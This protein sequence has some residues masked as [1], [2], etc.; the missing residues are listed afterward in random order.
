MSHELPASTTEP[1]AQELSIELPAVQQAALQELGKGATIT[2]AAQAA[3]V[4]RKTVSRWI[5]HDAVF[6][7]AYNAW[8]QELLDSGLGRA[9]AMSDAALTTIANAIQNGHVNASLQVVKQLGVLRAARPGSTDAHQP[10]LVRDQ[11][12]GHDAVRG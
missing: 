2:D 12:L 9:L 10:K 3:G 1:T 7:A 6:A 8:C 4:D 5:H 11:R